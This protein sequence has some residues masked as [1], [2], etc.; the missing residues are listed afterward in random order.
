MTIASGRM[1]RR[2]LDTPDETR[3]FQGDKGRLE[4]VNLDAGSVGRATFRPGWRWSE[5]VK[6]IAKT[7]SCEAAHQ[8]YVISGRMRIRMD[9]GAEEEFGPGDVMVAGYRAASQRSHHASTSSR[10]FARSLAGS[11]SSSW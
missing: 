9:D 4:L 10:T 1:V 3:P 2:N 7:P 8:G 6:P 11:F 5:H